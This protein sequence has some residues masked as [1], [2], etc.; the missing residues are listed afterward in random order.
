MCVSEVHSAERF[1]FLVNSV[2]NSS[3]ATILT[4]MADEEQRYHTQLEGASID[5]TWLASA[6]DFARCSALCVLMTAVT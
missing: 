1:K 6:D 2:M 3:I 5:W 4:E